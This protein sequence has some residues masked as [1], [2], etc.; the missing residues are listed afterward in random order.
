MET[1]FSFSNEKENPPLKRKVK[2]SNVPQTNSAAYNH[3]K[4]T[5]NRIAGTCYHG[6]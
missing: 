5:Q 1:L 3:Q 4:K 6:R 2:K